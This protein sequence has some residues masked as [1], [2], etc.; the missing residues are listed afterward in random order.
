MLFSFL[1]L[2]IP[3][4]SSSS[5]SSPFTSFIFFNMFGYDAP[6]FLST[7]EIS[8][9]N[10]CRWLN[11][12]ESCCSNVTSD[13]LGKILDHYKETLKIRSEAK[14]NQFFSYFQDFY[15]FNISNILNQSNHAQFI[16]EYQ[17]E[18]AFINYTIKNMAKSYSKCAHYSLKFLAGNLCF[19]CFPDY[20]YQRFVRNGTF[21]TSGPIYNQIFDNCFKVIEDA[22]GFQAFA[23]E[24]VGR[25][26]KVITNFTSSNNFNV[27]NNLDFLWKIR[28]L[29]GY[30]LSYLIDPVTEEIDKISEPLENIEKIKAI[31]QP[32]NGGSGI[33]IELKNF[34]KMYGSNYR[35]A[36][37]SY[38]NINFTAARNNNLKLNDDICLQITGASKCQICTEEFLLPPE[39]IY[40]DDNYI[41][42]EET[43]LK[44]DFSVFFEM[45]KVIPRPYINKC[46]KID[47]KFL[48]LQNFTKVNYFSSFSYFSQLVAA[49]ILYSDGNISF[50]RNLTFS[51]FKEMEINFFTRKMSL[52]EKKLYFEKM[53]NEIWQKYQMI[54]AYELGKELEDYINLSTYLK[55]RKNGEGNIITNEFAVLYTYYPVLKGLF[56]IMEERSKDIEDLIDYTLT[57]DFNSSCSVYKGN[58][59]DFAV[60]PEFILIE[61]FNFSCEKFLLCKK[62][63]F[64][65]IEGRCFS[66]QTCQLCV[67]RN[68]SSGESAMCY[69]KPY[70]LLYFNES[71]IFSPLFESVSSSTYQEISNYFDL[72]N[73]NFKLRNIAK[74]SNIFYS[75]PSSLQYSILNLKETPPNLLLGSNKILGALNYKFTAFC[76]F[77]LDCKSEVFTALTNKNFLFVPLR[78]IYS[79]RKIEGQFEPQEEKFYPEDSKTVF[80]KELFDHYQSMNI[81]RLKDY[82]S[83][84]SEEII[85]EKAMKLDLVK[86][87][88]E[89]EAKKEVGYDIGF[90]SERFVKEGDM[91]ELKVNGVGKDDNLE[92][93][94]NG[95]IE[96]AVFWDV[97]GNALKIMLQVLIIICAF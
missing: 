60:E 37:Y 39:I 12:L 92:K 34:L 46:D 75:S 19:S 17:K 4:S 38:F 56:D 66:H 47:E 81:L 6:P 20:L 16:L 33:S 51:V 86:N 18:I 53:E 57:C 24:A 76:K 89:E 71:N 13:K 9:H 88:Q 96:K 25:L 80:H 91:L 44:E 42:D 63:R 95:E 7:P 82:Y 78:Y 11:G 1:L 26:L 45:R 93:I 79:P 67:Y 62:L 35:E 59:S 23:R 72:E 85:Q 3:L 52:E 27:N 70:P 2:L 15:N 58:I 97:G 94:L 29:T 21:Y 77:Y 30:N 10:F 61:N 14:I 55:L 41:F 49:N 68:F 31:T 5:C 69:N 90:W 74:I 54:S 43:I 28:E 50:Q 36:Y 73:K 22:N 84:H 65:R 8:S 87:L 32:S 40:Y 48:I 64:L 83:L